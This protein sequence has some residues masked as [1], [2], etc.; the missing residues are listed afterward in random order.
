MEVE[1]APEPPPEQKTAVRQALAEL[2]I[3]R[4]PGSRIKWMHLGVLENVSGAD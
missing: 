1:L 4:R 3:E 2:S